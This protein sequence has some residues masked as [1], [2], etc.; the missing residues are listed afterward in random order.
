M[1]MR[2]SLAHSMLMPRW[3]QISVLVVSYL[4]YLLFF[5]PFLLLF[6]GQAK[7]LEA[8]FLLVGV[9]V[10]QYILIFLIKAIEVAATRTKVARLESELDKEASAEGDGN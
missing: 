4:G 6:L 5:M 2:H 3:W 10:F 8:L 9:I 7:L 1:R